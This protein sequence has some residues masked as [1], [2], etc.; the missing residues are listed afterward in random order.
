MRTLETTS[1]SNSWISRNVSLPLLSEMLD[2]R[3]FSRRQSLVKFLDVLRKDLNEAICKNNKPSEKFI[4]YASLE[5]IWTDNRL[6]EFVYLVRPGFDRDQIP[7]VKKKLLRTLSI[8]VYIRWTEKWEL[9]GSIFLHRNDRLDDRIPYYTLDTLNEFLSPIDAS[10]FNSERWTF[11]PILLEE[12]KSHEFSG[13]WRL[14]FINPESS[15]IAIGGYGQVTK[16]L[17]A[18]RQF[19]A[20]S[21]LCLAPNQVAYLLIAIMSLY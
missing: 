13:D 16:E 4:T 12:G 14:P 15:P 11:Y 21:S 9:F 5:D 10:L 20:C 17:I 18:S 3:P 8:L 7:F 2:F 6:G 19:V 1:L